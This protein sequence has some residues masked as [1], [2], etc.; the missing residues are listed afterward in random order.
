MKMTR[1]DNLLADIRDL[2]EERYNIIQKL[3]E[4]AL[5]AGSNVSEEVKYGGI[6]FSLGSP[7]CGVFSYARHVSLELSEGARLPDPYG[8]L[9]GGGKY[10][11]HIKLKSVSDIEEK[12]VHIYLGAAYSA[13]SKA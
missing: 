8:V 7:F 10:R 3:R 12:Y 9:E 5:S 1:V 6:L 4:L 2:S 11:R 13:V